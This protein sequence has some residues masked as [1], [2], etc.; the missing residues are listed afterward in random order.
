MDHFIYYERVLQPGTG[1]MFTCNSMGMIHE[2]RLKPTERVALSLCRA[3]RHGEFRNPVHVKRPTSDQGY[4]VSDM[5]TLDPFSYGIAAA[6]GLV[7]DTEADPVKTFSSGNGGD[8]GGAGAGG[9]WNSDSD[10]GSSCDTD[11][12]D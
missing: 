1:Y 5:T 11:S 2:T 3:N 9:S 8:F 10:S 7:V 4:V 6:R 12:S